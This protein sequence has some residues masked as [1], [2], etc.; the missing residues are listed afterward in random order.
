M[1]PSNCQLPIVLS[2][3]ITLFTLT[4]YGQ[5]KDQRIQKKWCFVGDNL[6]L[7][8]DGGRVKGNPNNNSI[9][10]DQNGVI[11]IPVVF[12]ILYHANKPEENVVNY[13]AS[14]MD[15]LNADFRKANSDIGQ[16][17]LIWQGLAADMKFEFKLAC[18]DPNGNLTDGINEVVTTNPNPF[19]FTGTLNML[20]P[21]AQLSSSYGADAWP[22]D[23]YLN[24]WVCDME[25]GGGV[26]MLPQNRFGTGTYGS[27]TYPSSLFDGIILDYT[28]VGENSNDPYYGKG[29]VLTHEVG[30]WLGLFHTYQ[31]ICTN[32]GDEVNDTP[33][34]SSPTI[35]CT[36]FPFTDVLCSSNYPGIMFMNYMDQT[37]DD[38]KYFFTTGQKDRARSYFSS[39]GPFGTRFPFINNYFGIKHFATNPYT[40]INNTIT[41]LINNPAC[42]PVSYSFT[43]PVTLESSND[44]QIVFSVACGIS[45]AISL[46]ATSGNYTDNYVF[47]FVNGPCPPTTGPIRIVEIPNIQSAKPVDIIRDIDNNSVIG[48]ASIDNIQVPNPEDQEVGFGIVKFD[49]NGN[50][51]FNRQYKL[52]GKKLFLKKITETYNFASTNYYFVLAGIKDGLTCTCDD[53]K[54]LVLKIDRN[55]G[56][57]VSSITIDGFHQNQLHEPF[58]LGVIDNYLYV[59]SYGHNKTVSPNPSSSKIYIVEVNLQNNATRSFY[60][61]DPSSTTSFLKPTNMFDVNWMSPIRSLPVLFFGGLISPDKNFINNKPFSFYSCENCL[62][63]GSVY[64]YDNSY[65]K[66]ANIQQF[67]GILAVVSQGHNGKLYFTNGNGTQAYFN[68]KFELLTEKS[69]GSLGG[70]GLGGQ[71]YGFASGRYNTS[72]SNSTSGYGTILF[73]N[74]G[75]IFYKK[76]NDLNQNFSLTQADNNIMTSNNSILY[77]NEFDMVAYKDPLTFSD[78][79]KFY[80]YTNLPSSCDINVNFPSVSVNASITNG[81]TTVLN[82]LPV[83]ISIANLSITNE[84]PV[85]ITQI[86]YDAGSF[87]GNDQD[88][89]KKAEAKPTE[90][91]VSFKAFILPNPTTGN[92]VN[93]KIEEINKQSLSNYSIKI[94]NRIGRVVL[95]KTNY[96]PG[97][98]LNIGNLEKGIYYVEIINLKGERVAK[99][100]VKL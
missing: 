86:C 35:G 23:K 58:S 28:V 36:A 47:D 14:Q 51:I 38:C 90:N 27:N 82:N 84:L 65:V 72:E 13:I 71:S 29:R 26:A 21:D 74:G 98:P 52:T 20:C 92:S 34:Q 31:G 40:V 44:H 11:I 39:G 41:V 97:S 48:Y 89:K 64:N 75:E 7:P 22:T 77:N 95:Q 78:K 19:C 99:S 4:S 1:K 80:N 88:F 87:S 55:N 63:Q 94:T 49:P 81:L 43:G 15:R 79:N 5:T 3:I 100:F 6:I 83:S 70:Q 85:I 73:G 33:P 91:P 53:Q 42:L 76:F 2:L 60:T 37:Q 8:T 12:H 18:I 16:V 57:I 50:K 45:G 9:L 17:P 67:D 66:T 61:Y 69:V 54:T 46:T 93:I 24:I 25:S 68:E 62:L 96:L 32:N 10:I 30:H 59:M 56:D